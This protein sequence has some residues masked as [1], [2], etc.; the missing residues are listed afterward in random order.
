ARLARRAADA[1]GAG[2]GVAD[3]AGDGGAGPAGNL[4]RARLV[5]RR[6]GIHRRDLRRREG[7]RYTELMSWLDEV[8]WDAN[9]LVPAI[10]QE[11]GSNDVLIIAFMNR[12]ALAYPTERG[13]AAYFS[14]SRNRL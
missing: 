3:A 12:G 8:K 5:R 2:D 13:A 7:R 6:A 11:V 9:G 1:R 10:A 14:R 4:A